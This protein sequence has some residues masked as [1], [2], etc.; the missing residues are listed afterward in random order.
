[1]HH[2]IREMYPSVDFEADPQIYGES[3]ELNRKYVDENLKSIE[4]ELR[5][6][7]ALPPN[8]ELP[9]EIIPGTLHDALEAY[10]VACTPP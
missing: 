8:G 3:L 4:G 1:M 5:Q 7:G 9:R 10:S 6:E 2:N